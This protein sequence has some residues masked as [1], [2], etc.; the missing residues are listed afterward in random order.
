VLLDNDVDASDEQAEHWTGYKLRDLSNRN[1][2]VGSALHL[3]CDDGRW[4]FVDV[5]LTPWR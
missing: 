1:Y 5:R 4:S 3:V 2:V